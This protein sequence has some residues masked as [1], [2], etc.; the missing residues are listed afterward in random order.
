MQR[1]GFQSFYAAL[2]PS[3]ELSSKSEMPIVAKIEMAMSMPVVPVLPLTARDMTPHQAR[4][5]HDRR[6][7][8]A[9]K[10]IL[11]VSSS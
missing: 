3:P 6:S 5:F 11:L 7:S 10:D 2:K 8:E 9:K 4:K 1:G